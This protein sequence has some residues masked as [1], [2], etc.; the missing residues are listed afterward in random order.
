MKRLLIYIVFSSFFICSCQEILFN[1]ENGTRE[2]LLED[3][4]VVKFSGIYN[5]I[6][7]QDSANK[8]VISGKN[9]INSIDA[10]VNNDTL[11]IDDH[12][13][14]SFNPAENSLY[15]HFT[16]LKFMVTYDPV[17]VSNEDTIK[18]D[19]FL[20]DAIG[21]IAEVRLVVD[22]NY[23][24]FANS[25]NTLGYSHFKGRAGNCSF[26][27]RYGC[28]IFAD[29]LSSKNTEVFNESAGDVYVNASEQISAYIWGPGN[30][31]YYGD[32]AVEIKEKRGDGKIIRL[33]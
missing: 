3:F 7:V 18:A 10:R 27:N 4:H 26:F 9:D 11:I 14:I 31:Y 5:I 32:P 16:N 15:L 6:L 13:K 25:A 24:A 2:I 28:T 23:F 33:N 19:Q 1:G 21:E 22:C 30:I 12:K 29:S 17:N 8:L 20:Y